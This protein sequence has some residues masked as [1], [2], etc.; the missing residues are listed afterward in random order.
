MAIRP[1]KIKPR[2]NPDE[3]SSIKLSVELTYNPALTSPEQL[4]DQLSK[5]LRLDLCFVNNT[6]VKGVAMITDFEVASPPKQT[7]IIEVLGGVL[8]TVHANP[9]TDV[10]LVDWDDIA[11][12]DTAGKIP[13]SSFGEISE[14]T[15]AQIVRADLDILTQRR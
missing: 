6:R 2:V 4:C 5:A 10:I 15:M 11:A 12:G 14:E 3:R 7:I 1:K 13:T 9:N 8:S